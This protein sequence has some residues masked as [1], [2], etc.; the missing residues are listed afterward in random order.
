MLAA[1]AVVLGPKIKELDPSVGDVLFFRF[2]GRRQG[3][4]GEYKDYEVGKG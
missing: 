2:L 4:N 1:G 3:K